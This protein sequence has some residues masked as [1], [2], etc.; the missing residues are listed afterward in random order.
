LVRADTRGITIHDPALGERKLTLKEASP[1]FTGV[2][3]EL[4]PAP[5]F[6]PRKERSDWKLRSLFKGQPG[7]WRAFSQMAVL[8]L[9][10]EVFAILMPM[11][12]QW[13]IDDVIVSRDTPLL[14][15]LA[16]SLG[17]L[18][19]MSLLTRL[20]RSWVVLGT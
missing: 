1:H 7:L 16:T 6:R 8:S 9:V 5:G 14:A 15:V 10:L 3:L 20:M 13:V 18:A 19:L 4:T 17:L 12:S 11:L 2:A